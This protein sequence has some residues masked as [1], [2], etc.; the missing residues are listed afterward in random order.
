MDGW[1]VS[2]ENASSTIKT[3]PR[4]PVQQLHHASRSPRRPRKVIVS[5]TFLRKARS[6]DSRSTARCGTGRPASG[7]GDHRVCVRPGDRALL[8]G[9]QRTISL[10]YICIVSYTYV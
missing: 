9:L 1:N 5:L 4:E 10:L 7:V 3:F 2:K 8:T 6:A